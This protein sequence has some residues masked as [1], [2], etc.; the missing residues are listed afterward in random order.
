M[1]KIILFALGAAALT[2]CV[3]DKY[4]EGDV[5]PQDGLDDKSANPFHID[6][7]VED[8][9]KTG[10]G[11]SEC[12]FWFFSSNDGRHMAAPGFT[13]DAG[14]Q[15]AKESATYD[16]VEKAGCDALM[17]AQYKWTKTSKFLGIYKATDVEVI[18]FPA[19]VKSI[20]MID[21]RPCVIGKDQQIIKLK[22]YETL[23]RGGCPKEK[24]SLM[25]LGL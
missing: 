11:H 6:Y 15:S 23:D 10:V 3:T 7:R 18:G 20:Q 21:E 8:V 19:H 1:K 12:W 25:P 2:G 24:K 17:G 5:Q 9:R 14:L 16:A 4:R 22:S 13:L